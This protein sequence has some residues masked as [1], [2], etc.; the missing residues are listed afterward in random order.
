M[1]P[2][3]TR[4][5]QPEDWCGELLTVWH[6]NSYYQEFFPYPMVQPREYWCLDRE[7]TTTL[8]KDEG[9]LADCE[10]EKMAEGMLVKPKNGW[11]PDDEYIRQCYK[12][13]KNDH[14]AF[15]ASYRQVHYLCRL[16]QQQ[17]QQLGVA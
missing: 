12:E 17:K 10:E 8:R 4:R 13:R 5:K 15:I 6:D 3:D 14:K 9:Y 16:G 1:P 11:E 2:K 7:T